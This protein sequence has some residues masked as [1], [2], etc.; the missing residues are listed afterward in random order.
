MVK[1]IKNEIV[2]VL[3]D[4]R[5]IHNV[6]SMFRTADGAGVEEVF[7]VGVTPGPLDRLGNGVKAFEKVSLGAEKSVKW[8]KLKN[9]GSLIKRLKNSGYAICAIEQDKR[10]FPHREM[11]KILSDRGKIAL[12]FGEEVGGI[13]AR[14]LAAADYIFEIPMRGMKESLNVSV[15]FGIAVYEITN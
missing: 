5:S 7:L 8:K 2:A 1:K 12:V 9:V 11:R 3:C 4:V 6:A 15:S 14:V 10:S 13:P